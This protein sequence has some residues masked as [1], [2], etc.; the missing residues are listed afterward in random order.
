MRLPERSLRV[1]FFGTP[2][3]GA[4]ILARLITVPF[5][6]IPLVVCQPDRPRGRGR[7]LES[8][9]VKIIAQSAGIEVQQPTKLKDGVLAGHLRSLDLDLGVV[10]AYGRLIPIEVFRAPAAGC[11]NVHTSLLPRHRGA[12]PIQHAILTGDAT[13]GITL[14]QLG[15][16]LDEGD[17][18][19]QRSIPLTGEETGASLT[20]ALSELGADTLEAGLARA[21]AEGLTRTV[22]DPN[23]VT[24]APLL[25][26]KDSLLDFRR[27]AVELERRVRAL[28]PWPGTQ[29]GLGGTMIKVRSAKVALSDAETAPGR[30]SAPGSIRRISERLIV[31]TGRDGL[32]LLEVQP[33]GK[34]PMAIADFLR[35]A[36]R[37]IKDGDSVDPIDNPHAP[38]A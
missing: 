2:E 35:G 33:P 19:L 22:Q 23:K 17:I 7:S 1:A 4:V 20:Q 24:Y 36:G 14:M 3:I 9:P 34:R 12:S 37:R 13:T 27:P 15:E 32:E 31:E 18:L 28:E 5:V 11:W 10:C 26:K 8:P 38:S 6:E 25:E 30:I 29:F 21:R 16:G